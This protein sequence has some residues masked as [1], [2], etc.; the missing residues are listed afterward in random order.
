MAIATPS[1]YGGYEYTFVEPLPNRYI[2]NICQLPSR[3]PYMTG[4]CCEGQTICKSCLDNWQKTSRAANC[5]VC[6]KEDFNAYPN[7]HLD[8]EIKGSKVYC[9]NKE[10]GCDWNRELN[11]I[12]NHLGNSDGCQFEE[13]KCFT[14]CG[15]MTER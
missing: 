4:E 13:V 5:P 7:Y 2:C 9:T 6:R 10:K 1:N 3:D 12:Y 8:R 15:K 14:E 11:D